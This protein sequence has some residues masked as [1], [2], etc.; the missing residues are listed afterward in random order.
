MNI[1]ITGSNG[2]IG[3][4]LAAFVSK[5]KIK[6]Y[7]IGRQNKNYN[8]NNKK[9]Y[10]KNI[11]GNVSIQNLK[12]FKKKFSYVL[13]CAGNGLVTNNK[14]IDFQ[15]NVV[16]I[17]NLLIYLAKYSPDTK[18]IITSSASVYGNNK[19][20]FTE[21]TTVKPI[22][23]YGENKYLAEAQSFTYWKKYGLNILILRLTSIYGEDMYKQFI[24]DSCVKIDKNI[25]E[26][27]G[28]GNETRD[29]L[30]ISD[31]NNLFYKIIK[32]SFYGF[33][34]YNCGSGKKRK[35]KDVLKYI[36]K[37][38][39][40]KII[41]NFNGD[42]LKENP[43]SNLVSIKKL[44]HFKWKPKKNFWQGLSDYIKWYS[45]NKKK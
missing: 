22:S 36:I 6:V 31:L 9:Y 39:K 32:K 5:R 34:V 45:N 41:P 4:K 15:K 11:V 27:Y 44:K 30:H 3:S 10:I 29:W 12:K 13:H 1:L 19:K 35:I 21:K 18:I 26:F 2:F 33:S 8:N 14:K 28:S 43:K 42:G 16:S 7:G 25:N 37:I 38:N 23:I 17:K 24:F 20:R 40:K